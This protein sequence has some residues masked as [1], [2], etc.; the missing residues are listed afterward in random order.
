MLN[1]GNT[2]NEVMVEAEGEDFEVYV[3]LLRPRPSP[4]A[5]SESSPDGGL[6]TAT[7]YDPSQHQRAKLVI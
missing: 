4:S 5:P 7:V 6:L 3:I 2:V 1:C